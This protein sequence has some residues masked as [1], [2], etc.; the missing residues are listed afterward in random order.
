MCP[1]LAELRFF[2]RAGI[3]ALIFGPGLLEVSHEPDEYVPLEN[4]EQACA[5]YALTAIAMLG[6]A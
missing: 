5:I 6:R 4:L 3:P 1:G 2:A